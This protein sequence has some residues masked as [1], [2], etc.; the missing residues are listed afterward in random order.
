MHWTRLVIG[1]CVLVAAATLGVET[2]GQNPQ[3]T[4]Q[5]SVDLIAVDVHVVDSEGRPIRDLGPERFEVTIDGKKRRVVSADL[6]D[7]SSTTRPIPRPATPKLESSTGA[8]APPGA[9]I[10]G[11]IFM[12]AVDTTSLNAAL[13]RRVMTAARAFV[14]QLAPRDLVG[15]F[16]WPIGP[17]MNP[18]TDHAAVV[19]SLDA[20]VGSFEDP[21]SFFHLRP[22]EIVELS[23]GVQ[24]VRNSPFSTITLQNSLCGGDVNCLKRLADEVATSV[25]FYEA[26]ARANLGTFRAL[27]AGLGRVD[28]SK[29]LVLVSAGTPASDVP[30]G[31]PDFAHEGIDIGKEAA[32]AN[33]LVYTLFIDQSPA[34]MNTAESRQG[35]MPQIVR[36]S[37]ILG[38]WLEQFT[39]AADGAWLKV[40]SGDGEYAFERIASETSVVYLLGVESIAADRDGRAHRIGVKTNVRGATV[41]SRGFVVVPKRPK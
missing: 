26:Q 4:F 40:L 11:R 21:S 29:T 36:D 3:A 41:R 18:T 22:S 14:Q 5:A 16:A 9:A 38:Q 32:K 28:G 20:I 13:C 17:Q 10:T 27:L 25:L 33:V 30:G 1:A 12:I 39:G 35:R 6:I 7:A 34:Q 15:V 19:R 24:G 8:P 31:R 37:E 23:R 2:R